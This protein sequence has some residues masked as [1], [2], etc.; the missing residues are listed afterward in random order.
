MDNQKNG[1]DGCE[2]WKII[3]YLATF[4]GVTNPWK[5]FNID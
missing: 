3:N 5:V 1:L 4:Q 2:Y